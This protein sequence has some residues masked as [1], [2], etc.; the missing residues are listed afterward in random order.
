MSKLGKLN[1][2]AMVIPLVGEAELSSSDQNE[3]ADEGGDGIVTGGIE[4]LSLVYTL[5]V[6]SPAHEMR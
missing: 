4:G 2:E 6:F 5:F 1:D 3:D